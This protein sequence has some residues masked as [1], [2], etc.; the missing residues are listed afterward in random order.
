MR[1]AV[2][3]ISNTGAALPI[4]CSAISCVLNTSWWALWA[5][6][7][8]MVVSP[9]LSSSRRHATLNWV[10]SRVLHDPPLH[11]RGDLA[12]GHASVRGWMLLARDDARTCCLRYGGA[13]PAT[14]RYYVTFA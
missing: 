14:C 2:P 5:V 1:A 4:K 12:R 7:W 3:I 6:V 9:L 11:R 13:A 8:V 10:A